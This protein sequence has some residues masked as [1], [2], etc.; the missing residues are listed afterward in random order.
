MKYIPEKLKNIS[1]YG[2]SEVKM[3]FYINGQK[4]MVKFPD[5]IRKKNKNISYINNHFSEHLGC[6]IFKLFC[7][8]T[9]YTEIVKSCINGKEKIAVA[10]KDFLSPGDELIEFKTLSYS[11]NP[12]KKYTSSI[13]DIYEM[14]S[15]VPDLNDKEYIKDEFWH[16]FVVD[17][18]IGNTDRHLGNWGLI[19]T[20]DS[21]HLAPVY[22]CGSCLNPLLTEEEMKSL[23]NNEKELKN[24]SCNLK[25]AYR[26][27]DKP[28]SYIDIYTNMPKELKEQI[29]LVTPII[30]MDKIKNIIDTTEGLS[31]IQ[32]EFYFKTISF[33]KKFLLD[34]AYKKLLNIENLV[35]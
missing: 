23:L 31:P 18:L 5:P 1:T 12:E 17:T 33:R 15:L 7:I 6:Q 34:R 4:F 22:D 32:K 11:L 19:K 20:K 14:L 3:T 27:K 9:Q 13:E 26:L 30:D 8:E 35:A 2:G 21:F 16:R 25:T 10:C 29:L 24:V 28:A